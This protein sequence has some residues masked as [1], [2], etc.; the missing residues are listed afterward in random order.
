LALDG[1][2]S[3]DD[4][5]APL[6]SVVHYCEP[7]LPGN[8]GCPCQNAFWDGQRLI[9]GDG[10]SRADDVVVHELT[11]AVTEDSARLFY[12]MQSGAPLRVLLGHLR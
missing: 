3:Y 4:A 12:Y 5:G 10:F 6:T 11:H 2:D 7:N 1:R 9:F 8:C